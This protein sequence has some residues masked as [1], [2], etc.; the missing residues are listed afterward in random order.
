MTRT[1]TPSDYL[2]DTGAID[3]FVDPKKD[4]IKFWQNQAK[5]QHS[6]CE[7]VCWEYL[8]QFDSNTNRVGRQRF[9]KALKKGMVAS[10]S[11]DEQ[12]TK[13]AVSLYQQ[14][15]KGLKDQEKQKRRV[16]MNELQCDVLIAAVAVRHGKAV[17]TDD[18]ADWIMLSEAVNNCKIGTLRLLFKEDMRDPRK[19]RL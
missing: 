11:M 15:R 3:L 4:T 19:W 9:V 8:R 16:R 14:V 1:L 10:L 13:Y 12:A 6:V 17:I 5:L 2:I 18:R 7:V